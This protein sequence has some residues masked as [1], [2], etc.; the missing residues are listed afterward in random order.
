LIRPM[1]PQDAAS[2]AAAASAPSIAKYMTRLF[3][4]PYTL[5]DA[6]A[7]IS[8]NISSDPATPSTAFVLTP[9]HSPDIVIG[10]IG[11]KVETSPLS[12]SK[13]V[14]ELAYWIGEEWA[15]RGWTTEAV[16]GL[17]EWVF[18]GSG[19]ERGWT[20]LWARVVRENV[21]S[22]KV[23]SRCGYRDEGVLR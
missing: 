15:G 8:F 18:E 11:L 9:L 19:M 23:L 16:R 5:S 6:Q 2:M 7:W 1:H 21:G 4:F 12:P 13:H 20:R 14:A 17:T 10:G 3:P 22:R